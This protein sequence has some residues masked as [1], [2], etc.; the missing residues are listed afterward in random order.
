MVVTLLVKE[1]ISCKWYNY[2]LLTRFALS[3]VGLKQI[4]CFDPVKLSSQGWAGILIR[5]SPPLCLFCRH[6]LLRLWFRGW[7]FSVTSVLKHQ[8]I[9]SS[10][11]QRFAISSLA[12]YPIQFQNLA[13]D[14]WKSPV[15]CLKQGSF[16]HWNFHKTRDFT[17]FG[18][19]PNLSSSFLEL[20][21]YSVC[22]VG[23][24]WFPIHSASPLQLLSTLLVFLGSSIRICSQERKVIF[25]EFN[26]V[27]VASL[28]L[29]LSLKT[30]FV[31]S[32]LFKS[33]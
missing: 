17:L 32:M 29:L 14:L 24:L 10:V 18:L 3:S 5:L 6:S 11:L 20:S 26:F 9:F 12:S 22:W 30:I 8:W 33:V 27:L 25:L 15:L 1:G 28:A 13:D 4:D 21:K 7:Q 23:L 2:F 16:F 31:K 19:A